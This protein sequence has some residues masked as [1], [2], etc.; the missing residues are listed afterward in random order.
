MHGHQRHSGGCQAEGP[1]EPR[2]R[3]LLE[4]ERGTDT[5]LRVSLDEWEGKPFVSLRVWERSRDG[6]FWPTKRG[7]SV[8]LSE[9]AA[10]V[11]TL[12][13]L[14]R[15][16]LGHGTSSQPQTP[17]PSRH[18][19][20]NRQPATS[21]QARRQDVPVPPGGSRVPPPWEGDD[22][23]SEFDPPPRGRPSHQARAET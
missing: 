14:E 16:G 23:F 9:I 13:A 4:C 8:R 15:E 17:R 19:V 21:T 12:V 7:C 5:L 20:P 1:P 2:G 10:L 18:D 11:G 6:A 22:Q 3:I